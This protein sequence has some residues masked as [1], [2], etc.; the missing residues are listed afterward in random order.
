MQDRISFSCPGCL[1][2]F[3][4]SVRFAARPCACP[5][6]GRQLVVPTSIPGESPPLLIL[7]DENTRFVAGKRGM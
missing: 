5:R 4:A 7:N 3:Q 2:R 1:A 6:C